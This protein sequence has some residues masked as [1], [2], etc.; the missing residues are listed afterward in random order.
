MMQEEKDKLIAL[1]EN[2]HR[3]CSSADAQDEGGQ[4]VHFDDKTAVSW[5]LVGGL[6]H[7]FGWK[8]A[9]K[10][11][12]PLSRHFSGKQRTT[13]LRHFSTNE[14]NEILAMTALLDFNDHPDTS[15][16]LIVSKLQELPVWHGRT[17][18]I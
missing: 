17:A 3:W 12:G 9:C 11:F 10:L 8:R 14:N 6:C 13:G 18:P 2:E 7:L 5:D 4:A 1:F 16:E 15:Y